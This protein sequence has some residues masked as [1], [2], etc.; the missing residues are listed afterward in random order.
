MYIEGEHPWRSDSSIVLSKLRS[1][2][3]HAKTVVEAKMKEQLISI[4]FQFEKKEYKRSRT[5]YY[6]YSSTH[7]H[8]PSE[9]EGYTITS[10]NYSMFWIG[11][12]QTA[13]YFSHLSYLITFSFLRR[14]CQILMHAS[15][16]NKSV[17]K[18]KEWFISFISYTHTRSSISKRHIC[19]NVHDFVLHV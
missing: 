18:L 12:S 15:K 17:K 4:G 8:Y 7:H 1:V 3:T 9:N 14:A 13:S 6:R 19:A 16:S 5:Y 10:T 11:R 2:S